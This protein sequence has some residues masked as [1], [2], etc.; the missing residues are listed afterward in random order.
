[1]YAALVTVKLDATRPEDIMKNLH[2]NVVARSKQAP[3]FVRGTW[4]GDG[5]RG[6]GLILFESEKQAQ[7]MASQASMDP[8]SPV[9]IESTA[10]Y[11]VNAEA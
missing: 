11:K 10:V 8:A 1:M 6:H 9:Q 5:E 2:E 4:F 3:G 7:D